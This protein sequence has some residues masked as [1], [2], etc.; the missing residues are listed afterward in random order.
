MRILMIVRPA[1]GGIKSH[2]RAL[3]SGLAARGHHVEIAAPGDSDVAIEARALGFTVH[4]ISLAGPLHPLKD[5]RAVAAVRGI[6]RSGRFDLVH[7]H[8]FKA[9]LV[10]RLGMRRSGVRTFV[11]TAHNH[12]LSRDETS[13]AA[14]WRY[15]FVERRLAGLVTRYIAV[16]D[17]VRNELID[18]YGLPARRVVTI[19]NGIE[20]AP[21][22]TPHSRAEARAD[23]GLP[24]NAPLVGLA[25]RF[26]TQKGLRHLISALPQLRRLEPGATLALGG[27][28]PLEAE[29]RE[30][31]AA[32]E[33]SGSVRWMGEV[34]DMPHFLAALDVYVSPSVTEALG[35]GLIE[36][37]AAG[38]AVVATNVGGVSEVVVDGETGLL[39]P[40]SDPSALAVAVA[41]LL[42]DRAL[43]QRLSSAARARVT[44]AFTAERMLDATVALYAEA[45][46]E[47]STYRVVRS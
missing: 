5:S 8:G 35:I 13:T 16:S 9:G 1:A 38:V 29:L 30:L 24:S 27:S 22:L 31:A 21:F 11:L 28:G 40:P 7:A 46:A 43:A 36:A 6:I 42:E 34:L 47:T 44:E 32:L 3:S 14:K 26:S 17:S 15:R 20:M 37:S 45:C 25:A 12:V 18:A 41:R 19:H 39:V 4:P 33:V 23:L 10:G 2:V